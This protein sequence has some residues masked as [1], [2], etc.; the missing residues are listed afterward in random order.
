M[1]IYFGSDPSTVGKC[2]RII[3]GEL[4]RLAQSPLSASTLERIKRQYCGQLLVSSDHMENRA[5]S[6]AK[7]LLYYNEIHDISTT[8]SHIME[9]TAEDLREVA[10][11]LVPDKCGC[12]TLV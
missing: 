3:A 10:E 2:R 5:M 6:L 1:L 9:V 4:D 11:M 8:A 12:L 7:S